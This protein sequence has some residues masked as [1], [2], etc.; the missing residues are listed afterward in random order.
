MSHT[1]FLSR[2]VTRLASR[3]HPNVASVA[4]ASKTARMAWAML[5]HGTNYQPALAAA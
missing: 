3:A 1:P 4:M 2:W 5:R